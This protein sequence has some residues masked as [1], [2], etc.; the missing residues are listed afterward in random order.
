MRLNLKRLRQKLDLKTEYLSVCVLKKSKNYYSKY[1]Q[2]GIKTITFA[3]KKS[4]CK[5]FNIPTTEQ[6]DEIAEI[7]D[8]EDITRKEIKA[9]VLYEL[10][11]R[12]N[13][14]IADVDL[15]LN[16]GKQTYYHTEIGQIKTLKYKHIERLAKLYHLSIENII[17]EL[18]N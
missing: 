15:F 5:A 8:V 18:Y 2:G 17:K 7:V 16:A 1:E 6:F 11:N 14:D 13:F 9:G 3:D 4:L 12:F 10:R